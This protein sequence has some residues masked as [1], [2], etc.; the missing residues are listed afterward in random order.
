MYAVNLLVLLQLSP[1]EFSHRN[2]LAFG[3]A[4]AKSEICPKTGLSL[5]MVWTSQACGQRD[6]LSI[7]GKQI[8][9]SAIIKW[10]WELA[11]MDD[12]DMDIAVAAAAF[13]GTGQKCKNKWLIA[14][15][16]LD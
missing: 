12:G 1:V 7:F 15:G 3:N 8:A 4:V 11:V 10:K 9:A 16:Q 6:Q 13:G 2:R 5:R 14:A